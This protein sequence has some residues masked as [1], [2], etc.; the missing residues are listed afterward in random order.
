GEP[1]GHGRPRR[2]R[3]PASPESAGASR[4]GRV[5]HLVT[6][7]GMRPIRA[8]V[9]LSVENDSTADAGS[10]RDKHKSR[11]A[12]PSSPVRFPQGAGVGI[13]LQGHLDAESLCQ[14]TPRILL[15][16]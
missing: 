3:L 6:N 5:N 10:N 2:Q 15:S 11:L 13:V 12:L 16:P 4:P 1:Y 14:V 8:T 7:L 9:E